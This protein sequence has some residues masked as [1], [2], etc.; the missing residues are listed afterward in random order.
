MSKVVDRRNLLILLHSLLKIQPQYFVKDHVCQRKI[1]CVTLCA[2]GETLTPQG[3]VNSLDSNY[4]WIRVLLIM[5]IIRLLTYV[6]SVVRV[7]LI[8]V[9]ILWSTEENFILSTHLT[10]KEI[11]T[12]KIRWPKLQRSRHFCTSFDLVPVLEVPFTLKFFRDNIFFIYMSKKLST[13]ELYFINL[14]SFF[15]HWVLLVEDSHMKYGSVHTDSSSSL[16][17]WSKTD[18]KTLKSDSWNSK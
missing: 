3:V 13:F 12:D 8:V 7:C 16:G 11:D 15:V 18:C 1:F 6:S 10:R 4:N 5:T 17:T 2:K 9:S 14:F